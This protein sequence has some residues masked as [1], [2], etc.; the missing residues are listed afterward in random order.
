MHLFLESV[1]YQPLDSMALTFD[2]EDDTKFVTISIIEDDVYE[3][4]ETFAVTLSIPEDEEGVDLTQPTQARVQIVDNDGMSL[5][6]GV[7]FFQQFVAIKLVY[8][9]YL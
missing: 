1:D 5:F 3:G 8:C 9:C 2:P 7:C 4:N 6:F